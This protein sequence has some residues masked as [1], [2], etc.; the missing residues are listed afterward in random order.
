MWFLGIGWCSIFVVSAALLALDLG[1]FVTVLGNHHVP[2]V[3]ALAANGFDISANSWGHEVGDCSTVANL[4]DTESACDVAF[5]PY[6]SNKRDRTF[7]GTW[8]F[9]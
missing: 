7:A 1:D 9:L 2:D 6:S 8:F 4:L 3:A 5:E